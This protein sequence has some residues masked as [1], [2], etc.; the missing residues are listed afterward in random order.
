MPLKFISYYKAQFNRTY[1][2]PV[3]YKAPAGLPQA[4]TLY[5]KIVIVTNYFLNATTK[6]HQGIYTTLD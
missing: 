1:C 6:Y 2:F 5:F 4:K 3:P